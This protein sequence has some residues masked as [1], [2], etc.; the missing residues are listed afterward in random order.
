MIWVFCINFLIRYTGCS[1]V[2]NGKKVSLEWVWN[3]N[4]LK[5]IS[6]AP[7]G[8]RVTIVNSRKIRLE[9]SDLNKLVE[10]LKTKRHLRY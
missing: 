7:K 6:F 4:S 1:W 8:K 2:T 5:W 3:Q 10:D 9:K